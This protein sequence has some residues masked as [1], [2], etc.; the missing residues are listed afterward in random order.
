MTS[1][2]E[3]ATE[4]CGKPAAAHFIRGEVGSYFCA[5]CYKRVH[6]GETERLASLALI[7]AS[8]ASKTS[9]SAP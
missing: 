7:P 3:C 8:S 4:G 9:Q 5:D 2:H 1:N 6:A